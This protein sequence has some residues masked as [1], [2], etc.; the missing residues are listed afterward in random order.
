MKRGKQ[1][2]Q[3]VFVKTAH[4]LRWQKFGHSG[5]AATVF[6]SSP[7]MWRPGTKWKEGRRGGILFDLLSKN[8]FLA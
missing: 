2:G 1:G 6:L 4:Y 3:P 8:D 5:G 7:T